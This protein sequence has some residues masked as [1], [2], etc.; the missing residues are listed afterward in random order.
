MD[1]ISSA[2]QLVYIWNRIVRYLLCIYCVQNVCVLCAVH[3]FCPSWF[4][5]N[6][7][8]LSLD[9]ETQIEY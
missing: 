7:F 2:R 3:C 6:D 5:N 4:E 9:V 1:K 8:C